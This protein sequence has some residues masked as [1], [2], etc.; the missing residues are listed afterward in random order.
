MSGGWVLLV[1]AALMVMFAGIPR[2]HRHLQ[3]TAVLGWVVVWLDNEIRGHWSDY[4]GVAIVAASLGV[5]AL[6]CDRPTA[7]R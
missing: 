6:R 2:R 1:A 3:L 7:P 4:L 5:L